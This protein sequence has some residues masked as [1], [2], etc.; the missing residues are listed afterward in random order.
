MTTLVRILV[1]SWVT[2]AVIG[3]G[4][5]L[6]STALGLQL[7]AEKNALSSPHGRS[8]LHIL[9]F[10]DLVAIPVLALIPIIAI[11]EKSSGADIAEGIFTTIGILTAFWLFARFLLRPILRFVATARIHEI[12]TSA[13]LLLV[14]G[15]TVHRYINGTG[16]FFGGYVGSGL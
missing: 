11:D 15:D 3:F 16:W 2:A 8:A 6:S 9:L 5:S 1:D 7:I 13:A 4:L 12:F 14:L 10:Q